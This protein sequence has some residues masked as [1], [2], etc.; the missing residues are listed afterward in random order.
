MACS[1]SPSVPHVNYTSY[2]SEK[3]GQR[4]AELESTRPRF[5]FTKLVDYLFI[6]VNSCSC[7][8][9]R[10]EVEF[11]IYGI[12]THH[13]PPH[14][15]SAPRSVIKKTSNFLPTLSPA[16]THALPNS[17]PPIPLS[18]YF[19]PNPYIHEPLDTAFI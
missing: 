5:G 10:P 8:S 16:R 13:P 1:K 3:K 2:Q 11:R 19:H 14:P 12:E 18:F 9:L 6:A 4:Q 17:L 7:P 15:P